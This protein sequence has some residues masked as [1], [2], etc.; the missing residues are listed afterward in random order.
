MGLKSY[1]DLEV[2]KR[3]IELVVQ[4]YSLAL[5]FPG[6]E[7]FGLVSQTQRAAVSI[8]ANIAEGYARSHRGD[9]LRHISFAKG[10]LAELETL[11]IVAS[12]LSYINK[13]QAKPIWE[14]LQIIGRM[15]HKLEKSLKNE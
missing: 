12:K 8:P 1:R 3:S 9:Y 6:E 13:D 5:L 15:L 10:S 14:E 11:L 4:V 7:K 2:W